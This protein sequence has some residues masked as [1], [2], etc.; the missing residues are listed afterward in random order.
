MRRFSCLARRETKAK[1]TK[2]KTYSEKTLLKF[3]KEHLSKEYPNP[4]E[5]AVRPKP[6]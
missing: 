6:C 4:E 2:R 5:R 3:V 1:E